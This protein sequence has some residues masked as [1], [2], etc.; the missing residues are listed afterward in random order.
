VLERRGREVLLLS[1]PKPSGFYGLP[2]AF[3]EMAY[4]VPATTRNWSTV[5]RIA[6][7][8]AS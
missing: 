8:L 2:N 1:R 4:G 6:K 3:V 5:T 7:R